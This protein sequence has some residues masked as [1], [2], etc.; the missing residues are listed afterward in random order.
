MTVQKHKSSPGNYGIEVVVLATAA[1]DAC[2][3]H[4]LVHSKTAL[5]V[6]CLDHHGN[7]MVLLL[8]VLLNVIEWPY[9]CVPRS[10]G[11]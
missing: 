9:I 4:L 3:A 1:E 6:Q 10:Q 2:N 7:T 11:N 8:G 5:V